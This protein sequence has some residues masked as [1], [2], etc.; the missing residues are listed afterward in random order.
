[1]DSIGKQEF[2]VSRQR[3]P[4]FRL[5][6]SSVQKSSEGKRV[7][8]SVEKDSSS[9]ESVVF[10][11][12]LGSNFEEV[13]CGM[14]KEIRLKWSESKLAVQMRRRLDCLSSV[15]WHC[16]VLIHVARL[17]DLSP[18]VMG[19]LIQ[20]SSLK[21]D[22]VVGILTEESLPANIRERVPL[23]KNRM[24][25]LSTAG[26]IYA[27]GNQLAS[28]YDYLE[29][30][31]NNFTENIALVLQ[32]LEPS[33]VKVTKPS[34]MVSLLQLP[35]GQFGRVYFKWVTRVIR[36]VNQRSLAKIAIRR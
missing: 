20:L 22:Q 3:D 10:L 15:S 23:D 17:D 12:Q 30:S 18:K 16:F 13:S 31:R 29:I 34:Q 25:I 36:E 5:W 14:L 28:I 33:L 7:A 1:M 6:V 2:Q 32:Q 26:D 11:E 35:R 8:S 24:L 19:D 21:F 9:S 27:N 4:L